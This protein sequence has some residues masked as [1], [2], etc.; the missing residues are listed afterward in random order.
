MGIGG[1]S[2]M[3]KRALGPAPSALLSSGA[4]TAPGELATK[5]TLLAMMPQALIYAAAASLATYSSQLGKAGG[6]AIY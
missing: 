5:K 1:T 3:E 6:R 2:E 4:Y